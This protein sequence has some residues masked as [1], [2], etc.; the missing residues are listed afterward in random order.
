MKHLPFV[1][2]FFGM[3]F[4]ACGLV[5]LVSNALRRRKPQERYEPAVRWPRGEPAVERPRCNGCTGHGCG[6]PACGFTEWYE[7]RDVP[8]TSIAQH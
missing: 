4:A 1:V 7:R 8:P 3:S 5:V 6:G 2:L